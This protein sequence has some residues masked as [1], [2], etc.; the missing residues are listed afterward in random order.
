MGK[1]VYISGKITGD[2]NYMQKFSEAE[3]RLTKNG[4]SVINPTVINRFS[5]LNYSQFLHVDYALLDCCDAIYMLKDWNDSHG[6]KLERSHAW[7]K[8]KEIMYEQ[9]DVL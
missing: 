1:I 4:F 5:F 9:G 8:G 2:D 3:E 7:E 6:A